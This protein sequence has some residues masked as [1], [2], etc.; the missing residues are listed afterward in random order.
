MNIAQYIYDSTRKTSVSLRCSAET[1]VLSAFGVGQYPVLLSSHPGEHNRVLRHGTAFLP[2]ADHSGQDVPAI[3]L[4][5]QGTARVATAG[6]L[7]GVSSAD[8]VGGDAPAQG[9]ATLKTGQTQSVVGVSL[10][11]VK[12]KNC[13]VRHL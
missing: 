8:H 1:G 2:K 11:A 12:R 13:S 10:A 3:L 6:S 7:A 4:D 5:H 9:R